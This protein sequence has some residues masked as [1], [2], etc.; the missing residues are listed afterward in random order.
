MAGNIELNFSGDFVH[1]V[2]DKLRAAVPAQY[3]ATLREL[4]ESRLVLARGKHSCI[5]GHAK[6]E[7]DVHVAERLQRLELYND[8]D[9]IVRRLWLSQATEVEMDK[10]GRVLLPRKLKEIA[11]VVKAAKF[12]GLGPFFEIWDPARYE[13]FERKYGPDYDKYLSRLDGR[14]ALQDRTSHSDG[15]AQREVP[16][17]GNGS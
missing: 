4:K 6:R 10:Q 13:E 3:R 17:A 16:S 11:G 14:R 5:E 2:D 7:W 1:S 12:I 8:D 15:Q 9:L